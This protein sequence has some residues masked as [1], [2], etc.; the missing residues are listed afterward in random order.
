MFCT[1]STTQTCTTESIFRLLYLLINNIS[2]LFKTYFGNEY[3]KIA[4]IITELVFKF[5]HHLVNRDL[6]S[7]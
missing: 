3:K 6:Y 7:S 5:P 2:F 4:V 1:G